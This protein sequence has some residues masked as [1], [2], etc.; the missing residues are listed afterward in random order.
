MAFQP[1]DVREF[2]TIL[3]ARLLWKLEETLSKNAITDM[4]VGKEKITITSVE[5]SYTSSEIKELEEIGLTVRHNK[6]LEDSIKEFTQGTAVRGKRISF[7]YLPSILNLHLKRIELDPRSN[8]VQKINDY[9]EFPDEFD[10]TP[11]LSDGVDKTESWVYS[12][13]CVTVHEGDSNRGQYHTF[14]RPKPSGEFYKFE[15][16]RVTRATKKEAMN[17]NFGSDSTAAA[18]KRCKTAVILIYVRKSR[19]DDIFCANSTTDNVP[20]LLSMY[21]YSDTNCT[22]LEKQPR[23]TTLKGNK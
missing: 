15:D 10:A 13:Y 3:M 22:L 21:L 17:N 1:G 5:T 6:T 23:L 18:R 11:Y 7:D 2:S 12:L 9:H 14:L 20:P 4:F 16:D 8:T 19:L